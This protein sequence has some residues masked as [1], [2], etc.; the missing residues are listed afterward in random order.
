MSFH[1]SGNY[2]LSAGHDGSVKLYDCLKEA[3]PLYTVR[4]H[5]GAV[6]AVAFSP[7]G[8]FFCTGGEDSQVRMK[9]MMI[10][11]MMIMMLMIII[12]ICTR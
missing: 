12:M 11:M 8:G 7:N 1:P 2:L 6:A 5:E 9:M 10:M 3:R 4:G